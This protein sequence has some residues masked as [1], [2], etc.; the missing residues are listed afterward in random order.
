MP[1]L[2]PSPRIPGG[3]ATR[4]LKGAVTSGGRLTLRFAGAR[5]KRLAS[6]RYRIIVKDRS[7]KLNFHLRGPGLN[8]KTG[9]PAKRGT[10]RWTVTLV[11]GR[12]RFGTDAGRATGGSF[13]VRG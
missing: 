12:Y 6:G 13:R 2:P 10:F 4:T 3:T 9:R 8:K 7:R 1:P 11:P 5:A